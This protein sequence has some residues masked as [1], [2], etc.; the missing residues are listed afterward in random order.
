MFP[1]LQSY[2]SEERRIQVRSR[3]GPL[4]HT[5]CLRTAK[6][7]PTGHG[8]RRVAP[9]RAPNTPVEQVTWYRPESG[10]NSVWI[11]CQAWDSFIT[12]VSLRYF[13]EM[14]FPGGKKGT[15]GLFF[16]CLPDGAHVTYPGSETQAKL[17]PFFDRS[18]RT[19]CGA[20]NRTVAWRRSKRSRSFVDRVRERVE[21]LGYAQTPAGGLPPRVVCWRRRQNETMWMDML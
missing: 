11:W 17:V 7:V 19:R 13:L 1:I 10:G 20:S 9:Y 21:G 15:F 6:T 4:G 14:P 16:P 5:T 8:Y 2:I 3:L 18:R 12:P